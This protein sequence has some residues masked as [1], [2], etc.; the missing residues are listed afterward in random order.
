MIMIDFEDGHQIAAAGAFERVITEGKTNREPPFRGTKDKLLASGRDGEVKML[1]IF[2]V[3][4]I[5]AVISNH[6]KMF[7][8]DVANDTFD[9]I[10]DGDC[11]R[12]KLFIF[13][14]VVVKG[15]EFAVIVIDS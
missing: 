3:S 6:L 14:A 12:N 13:M 4:G 9:E 7:I 8:G 1:C 2:I 10:N 15:N 11:F 5:K